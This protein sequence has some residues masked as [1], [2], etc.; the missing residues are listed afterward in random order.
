MCSYSNSVGIVLW[1]VC[2]HCASISNT[3]WVYI[4]IDS[5]LAYRF[6]CHHR[7]DGVLTWWMLDMYNVL[8]Q[9]SC[10]EHPVR[11][12]IS[13]L[14]VYL[15]KI[16]YRKKSKSWSS[17]NISIWVRVFHRLCF[18]SVQAR[19]CVV[20]HTIA[21]RNIPCD[22]FQSGKKISVRVCWVSVWFSIVSTMSVLWTNREQKL[23]TKEYWES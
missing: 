23:E 11:F 19:L 8:I 12:Y 16:I 22:K 14:W 20:D 18:D 4:D 21:Q 5:V 1:T 6:S 17:K 13:P 3:L 10:S 15:S 2:L 7:V 9:R